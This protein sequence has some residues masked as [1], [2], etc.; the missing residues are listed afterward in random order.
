[1]HAE[2]QCFALRERRGTKSRFRPFSREEQAT[3]VRVA[4]ELDCR[5]GTTPE[6]DRVEC[7]YILAAAEVLV[8]QRQLVLDE[9]QVLHLP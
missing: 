4:Q 8:L 1:M 5:N 6:A 3:I 2:C 9:E 7:H